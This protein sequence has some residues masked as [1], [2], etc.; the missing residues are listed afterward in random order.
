LSNV[1]PSCMTVKVAETM[2]FAGFRLMGGTYV[3]I[4]LT[5]GKLKSEQ[6]G[7]AL[8][9]YDRQLRWFTAEGDLIPLPEDVAQQQADQERQQKERLENYLRSQGLD[10]DNLP[11]P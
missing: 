2:E 1:S 10:P 7:L 9:I 11:E 4:E 6:L 5:D 8:G 3:E